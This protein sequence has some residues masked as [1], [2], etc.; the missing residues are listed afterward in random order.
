MNQGRQPTAHGAGTQQAR[1]PGRGGRATCSGTRLGETGTRETRKDSERLGQTRRDGNKGGGSSKREQQRRDRKEKEERGERR[2]RRG[3]PR[4]RRGPREAVAV[5]PR[6]HAQV[7]TPGARRARASP[8]T[9]L[10]VLYAYYMY[11]HMHII[12]IISII[13]RGC[14]R[15]RPSV[16]YAYYCIIICILYV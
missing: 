3:R 10:S 5:L 13:A 9:R 8:R 7:Q 14:P 15:T 12:C 2:R 11:N 6:L 16:L 4:L 1:R